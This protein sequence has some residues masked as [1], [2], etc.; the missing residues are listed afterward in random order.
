MELS[1]KKIDILLQYALAVAAEEDNFSDRYLGPIHLVK[2]V[3]LADLAYAEGKEGISYTG[4][5]WKFHSFGPWSFEVYKR[6]EPALNFISAEKKIFDSKYHEDDAVRWILK[7]SPHLIEELEKKIELIPRQSIKKY[8][9]KFTSHTE[10]LLSYVYLTKPMLTAAPGEHLSFQKLE[11]YQEYKTKSEINS[12]SKKKSKRIQEMKDRLQEKLKTKLIEK[13][14]HVTYE[15]F[16]SPR[17]DEV[18]FQGQEWLDS[19]EKFRLRI[20]SSNDSK[21]LSIVF[22]HA[23]LKKGV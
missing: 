7:N 21:F 19:D 23:S 3:Y 8:V 5:A 10:L 18:F 22:T 20:G 13:Q 15:G 2:Y 16:S 12:I 4:T 14:S 17:Y 11:I 9:H 6:I 1:T